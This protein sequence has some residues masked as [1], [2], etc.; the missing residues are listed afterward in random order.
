MFVF[1][2]KLS[3]VILSRINTPGVLLSTKIRL[4]PL[5]LNIICTKYLLVLQHDRQIDMH[6][7]HRHLSYGEAILFITQGLHLALQVLQL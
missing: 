3:F 4:A 2:I 5:N 1:P 7:M 6:C